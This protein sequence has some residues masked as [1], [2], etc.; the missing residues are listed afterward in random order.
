MRIDDLLSLSSAALASPSLE[1]CRAL[2]QGVMDRLGESQPC[3]IEAPG[4]LPCRQD[5]GM[6]ISYRVDVPS[7]WVGQ[8]DPIDADAMAR[9]LLLASDSARAADEGEG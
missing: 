9:M 4:I 6:P 8:A 7:D 5:F 2:A 1:L 3:G